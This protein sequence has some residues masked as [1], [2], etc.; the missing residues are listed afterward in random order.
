MRATVVSAVARTTFREFWRSPEAVFWTYGFPVLMAVVLG[1]AFQPGAL[2]PVPVAVVGD[3]EVAGLVATLEKEPRL[4]VERMSAEAADRALARGRVALVVRLDGRLEDG[5]PVVRTDPTRQ[6]AE[7][8]RLLVERSLRPPRAEVR[9]VAQEIEERPGSRYID[10]L[11]P[12]LIGLNLLGAGMWGVGFNLVEM[13]TKNLL[14][15]LAVTPMR[16]SEFLFGYLLGRFVLVVPESLAIALFGVFVWGV[17]WRGSIVAAMLLVLVGG[18]AF[19]GLGCLLACRTRTIEGIAGLMNLF[20]LPMWLLGGAFFDN[21]R[22]T[23]V[24]RC[25]AEAMPLTHVNRAL[26][27]VMLE[28]GT[29][30]DIALPLGL[31]AAFAVTCFVVSLRL[32]RWH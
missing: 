18:F 32:F 16:R 15:R 31:L 13:R 2:P 5:A 4:E 26:R 17:P 27:D 10:F 19:A 20:Q 22:L 9:A 21:E 12:G 1:F 29:L 6:E 11:I 25:A 8:A 14:R 7:V 24:V 28:P 3:T 23:G 30:A